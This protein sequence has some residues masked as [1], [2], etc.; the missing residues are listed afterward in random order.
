MK[1]RCRYLKEIVLA[2][3]KSSPTHVKKYV[4]RLKWNFTNFLIT[5]FVSLKYY[6]KYINFV[7]CSQQ[8]TQ[9]KINFTIEIFHCLF[10]KTRNNKKK[11]QYYNKIRCFINKIHFF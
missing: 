4:I 3:N 8:E 5:R 7:L 1:T 6:R 10:Y 2:E 9:F 11:Q